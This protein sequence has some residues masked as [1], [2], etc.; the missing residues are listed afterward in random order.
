LGE[1]KKEQKGKEQK[2][3]EQKGKKFTIINK[4]K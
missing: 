3:K 2:G 4:F 1:L